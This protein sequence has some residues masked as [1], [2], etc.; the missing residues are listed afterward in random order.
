MRKPPAEIYGGGLY[1]GGVS[2]EMMDSI[3]FFHLR[4]SIDYR[5]LHLVHRAMMSMLYRTLL[6]KPDSQLSGEGRQLLATYGKKTDF[7][8]RESIQPL[9]D[10]IRTIQ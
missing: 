7:S 10:Y 1:A 5:R 6:K 3:E 8:D 2:G 9:I 4:G